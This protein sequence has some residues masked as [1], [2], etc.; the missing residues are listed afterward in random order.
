[1]NLTFYIVDVFAEEKYAGNQ[2]AV[3]R[4][5][6]GLPDEALQKIALEMNYSE[7]TF[8]L[9]GRGDRWRLRRSYLHAWR[10]GA[11][12]RPP[13]PGYGVRDPARD[14]GRARRSG[15]PQ[16]EGRQD[17]RDLRRR[18]LDAPAPAHLRPNPRPRSH[19]PGPQPRTDRTWT[20]ASPYR[21]YPP[22]FRPS[23]SR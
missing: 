15:N 22:G 12:R 1:M 13:D 21:R 10:G 5:G 9:C 20:T 17:P 18:A 8:V 4:G 6:A 2:L 16:P 14:P 7:T 3:V 11:F 23:S 19:R